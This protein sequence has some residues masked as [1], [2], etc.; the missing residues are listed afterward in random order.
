MTSQCPRCDRFNSLLC[1]DSICACGLKA[2]WY[3]ILLGYK[4]IVYIGY[5]QTHIGW[6]VD[7]VRQQIKL[8][9]AKFKITVEEIEKLLILR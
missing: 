9:V 2:G 5:G 8:P 6:Y 1:E 4:Y 3:R 7:G